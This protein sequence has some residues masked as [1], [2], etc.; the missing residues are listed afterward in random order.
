V[1]QEGRA[2]EADGARAAVWYE[3]ACELGLPEGCVRLGILHRF[4]AG[5]RHD[6]ARAVALFERACAAGDEEGCRLR[7][8][9]V[10]LED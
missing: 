8:D 3:R 7:D 6:E 10:R 5:V 9:P 2:L 1:L 4:G